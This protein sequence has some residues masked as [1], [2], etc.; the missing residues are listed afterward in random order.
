MKANSKNKPLP[1]DLHNPFEGRNPEEMWKELK[2]DAKHISRE[3]LMRRLQ[4]E[5][6]PSKKE[7]SK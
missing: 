5:A 3:E 6:D 7:K 4:T 2:K 1:A